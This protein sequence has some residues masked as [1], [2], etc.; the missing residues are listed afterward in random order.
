MPQA[1]ECLSRTAAGEQVFCWVSQPKPA[2]RGGT[3]LESRLLI[4]YY[5]LGTGA[6]LPSQVPWRGGTGKRRFSRT[7]IKEAHEAKLLSDCIGQKKRP[8]GQNDFAS[9]V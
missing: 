6:V 2:G 9:L 3:E 4:G 7:D 5:G 8:G 1:R